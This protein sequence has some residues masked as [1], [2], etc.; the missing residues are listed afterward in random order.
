[1]KVV[2]V[3][4]VTVSVVAGLVLVVVFLASLGVMLLA[5]LGLVLPL[6]L[7]TASMNLERPLGP[8]PSSHLYVIQTLSVF[9]PIASLARPRAAGASSAMWF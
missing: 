9:K 4:V 2:A 7:L 6:V 5:S 1:M 3:A 8:G